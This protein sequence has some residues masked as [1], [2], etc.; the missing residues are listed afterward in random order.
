[1]ANIGSM[2]ATL[3]IKLQNIQATQQVMMK[4]LQTISAQADK[5]KAK[6]AGVGDGVVDAQKEMSKTPPPSITPIVD[7]A[8]AMTALNK[9]T[10]HLFQSAQRWRTFGYL[11]S[12]VITAP[13]IAAGKA[14]ID[15][16]G[17]FNYAMAKIRGLAG[18]PLGAIGL[19]K[20]ELKSLAIQTAQTPE[21]LAEAAY[22]TASA[23]FKDSA[24]VLSIVETSAKMA[25]AGMGSAADNAKVL[26]FSMNAYRKSG[27]TAAKAAD[28]F[29][30]AVTEG[31]IETDQFSTAM[32]QVL[33]IASNMGIGLEQVAGSMAAMSLQ[34]ASAQNSAV[35]LKGMLNSL[36]KIKPNNA[37]GKALAEFGITADDLYEQLRK[38]GGLLKVLIQLQELSEKST[39]NPFLKDIFRDIRAMTGALSLTG[40]NLEYNAYVMDQVAKASGTM[41]NAYGAVQGQIEVVKNRIKALTEVMKIEFGETLAKYILPYIEKWINRLKNLIIWFNNTNEG[42]KKFVVGAGTILIALGPLALLGSTLKYIWAGTILSVGKQMIWL[43][44]IV[45]GLNGDMLAMGNAAAAKKGLTTFVKSISSKALSVGGW[46]VFAKQIGKLALNFGKVAAPIA[47]VTT[48]VTVGATKF[49]KYA[50]HIKDVEEQSRTWNTTILEVNGSL[51]KMNEL[52][53]TDIENMSVDELVKNRENLKKAIDEEGQRMLQYIAN[54]DMAMQSNRKN[55]KEYE[56]SRTKLLEMTELYE[57]MGVQIEDVASA[58]HNQRLAEDKL[59]RDEQIQKVKEYNEALQEAFQGIKDELTAIDERA[60]IFKIDNIPFDVI[61]E[62]VDVLMKGIE[63][64]SGKEFKLKYNHPMITELL[65][66]L[67]DLNYDFTETGKKAEEFVRD[68]NSSLEGVKVKK[69]LLGNLY[70]SDAAKLEIYN[71]ALDNFVDILTTVDP[72]TGQLLKPTEE[73]KQ[74]LEDLISNVKEYTKIVNDNIDRDALALVYAEADAFG[75]VA[76]KIEVVNQELQASQKYLRDMLKER[77]KGGGL[78]P[79]ETIQNAVDRIR[80]LKEEYVDLQNSIDLQ[81]AYD[82]DKA[83]GNISTST[84]LLETHI[85][86]LT[87][88]L[89]YLSEEGEGS[90]EAFKI[91]ASQVKNLEMTRDVVGVLTNS[92]STFFDALIEGGQNMQEVLQGIF[93]SIIKQLMD[94]LIQLLAMRILAAII[95]GPKASLPTS[96]GAP[97]FK[98]LMGPPQFA[99]GGIVPEGFP[100]DSYPAMLT[101][102]ETVVPKGLSLD[103][104]RIGKDK[105]EFEDVRF[106]IEGD[107]LVGILKK[108]A[109]KSNIY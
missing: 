75:S 32:Q 52:L 59:K 35:Y 72:I 62:K 105:T 20:D 33:P 45:K 74:Q 87:N 48:A 39:G 54:Q 25:T 70:D 37:A 22:F 83:F 30:A 11:T 68:L 99:K 47:L 18:I 27:L 10:T 3:G 57:K 93:K 63:Q 17:D 88:K 34:G 12:I 90:S 15:S 71:K 91:I 58:F 66:L 16:A 106:E 67:R 2:Y 79:D 29:T 42:F 107:V 4:T 77:Q 8:P 61:K 97:M 60:K 5:T 40:E 109:K 85:S 53:G 21:A 89:K 49:I 64:L 19:L 14:A 51:K 50:K 46:A 108:K 65:L 36:L 23:G 13:L 44:N 80:L 81:Y 76:A 92:F 96:K 7:T 101:S 43:R 73:Q 94:V 41:E 78:I 9:Y 56:K 69:D 26:V 84:Q 38:P 86:T 102:G 28:I 55:Q 31:A 24:Q 103:K 1:M 82:M 95:G 6:L 98:G 104:F 100:N